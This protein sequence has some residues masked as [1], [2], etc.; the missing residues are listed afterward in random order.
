FRALPNVMVVSHTDLQRVSDS[1]NVTQPL[2]DLFRG[3]IDLSRLVGYQYN[4]AVTGNRFF[5]RDSQLTALMQ[6]PDISYLV[7]GTRMSGKTS[8][9]MEAKRRLEEIDP[10]GS[11]HRRN[12]IYVDCK[13]YSTVAGLI[14]AILTE[15]E[16]RTSF[17]NIERWES[18]HR[19]YM[20]YCYLR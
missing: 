6:R 20:F 18:P 3:Q 5:G 15:M 19:W 11:S 8:L 16:E 1:K 4:G 10:H 13:R 9:L 2:R 7:T 12:A 17:S 14:N